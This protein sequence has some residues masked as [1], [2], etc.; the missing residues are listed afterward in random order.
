MKRKEHS[1]ISDVLS[2]CVALL[3][4]AGMAYGLCGDGI[5]DVGETCDTGPYVGYYYNGI[6]CS[7]NC[8]YQNGTGAVYTEITCLGNGNCNDGNG[9]TTDRCVTVSG[10]G[11]CNVTPTGTQTPCPAA[12][13]VSPCY[14]SSCVSGQ[15]RYS[16][17]NGA[18]NGNWTALHCLNESKCWGG[19]QCV[20]GA[21]V[22]SAP[23][24]TDVTTL[25]GTAR[26]SCETNYSWSSVLAPVITGGSAVFPPTF[27]VRIDDAGQSQ[28]VVLTQCMYTLY[29]SANVSTG[30]LATDYAPY[31][32]WGKPFRKP[33]STTWLS[34]RCQVRVNVTNECNISQTRTFT[35][36]FPMDPPI[37]NKLCPADL[38]CTDFNG[39][40]IDT[41]RI[42]GWCRHR[43]FDITQGCSNARSCVTFPCWQASC[44]RGICTYAATGSTNLTAG[45][46]VSTKTCY[47]ESACFYDPVCDPVNDNVV[48]SLPETFSGT[49]FAVLPV[50]FDTSVINVRDMFLPARPYVFNA[51]SV[52][53]HPGF[54][55]TIAQTGGNCA[56][57]PVITGSGTSSATLGFTG[58]YISTRPHIC[59]FTV[60]ARLNCQD[61]TVLSGTI[62]VRI[63]RLVLD[64][65]NLVSSPFGRV[66]SPFYCN[67]NYS[68]S[69]F[70]AATLPYPPAINPNVTVQIFSSSCPYTLHATSGF[71]PVT[72]PWNSS[73]PLFWWSEPYN[74]S[75]P[76]PICNMDMQVTSVDDPT[77]FLRYNYDF[78]FPTLLNKPCI[79]DFDCLGNFIGERATCGTNDICFYQPNPGSTIRCN[80]ASD[81]EF[82]A[83]YNAS[84]STG[85]CDYV[86]SG[87]TNP[88]V[89]AYGPVCYPETTCAF[90]PTCRFDRSL[91]FQT[92]GSFTGV[93]SPYTTQH[94]PAST[95]FARS[96]FLPASPF[97]FTASPVYGH[98]GFNYTIAQI[99]SCA[100]TVTVALSGTPNATITLAGPW[101]STLSSTCS[102]A[103]TGRALCSGSVITSGTLAIPVTGCGDGVLQA[104]EQCDQGTSNGLS[105]SCCN[106]TCGFVA[107]GV[108]RPIAGPCDVAETCTGVSGICPSDGYRS[109]SYQCNVS[110]SP[111]T[112]NITCSGLSAGCPQNYVINGGACNSDNN[113][114]SV[115]TCDTAHNCIFQYNTS[116]DDGFYCNGVEGC[117]ATTGLIVPGTPINCNDN[118]SCTSDSCSDAI[119]SCVHAPLPNTTGP[120]GFNSVGACV[121]GN[122]SCNGTGV[123]PSV[124]CVGAV[125]PSAEICLPA[126]VDENC[127]GVA[128]EGCNQTACTVDANCTLVPIA[129]CQRVSCDT[130]N[131]VCVISNE[132][133][134]TS[135]TDGLSCTLNDQCN[136]AG[137]CVGTAAVC[138]DNNPCTQDTCLEPSGI[139]N[140]DGAALA[141]TPCDDSNACTY[142][143]ACNNQG[144][145]IGGVAITCPATGN[146]CTNSVCNTTSGNCTVVNL[147]GAC[148][149]GLACTL[150][151]QCINGNCT[152]SQINCNDN[153]ACTTDVCVEPSGVCSNAL[154]PGKCYVE[155][156]CYSDG[157][158]SP[159]DPCL[160]CNS[161]LSGVAWSYTQAPGVS[162]TDSN[163]CTVGDVCVFATQTCTGAPVDCSNMTNQCNTGSCSPLS[164]QC[165]A[166]PVSSGAPCSTGLYCV[167]GQTCAAGSCQGGA[168]RDCSAFDSQCSNGLCN[169]TADTCYAAPFLDFTP[170]TLDSLVCNGPE[171]CASGVCVNGVAPTCPASTQCSYYQCTEPDGCTQFFNSLQPCDDGNVCT[172]GDFCANNADACTPGPTPLNCNDADAC[173]NDFCNATGGCYHVHL[174]NC[175]NCAVAGDCSAAVCY[176][177]TC[178]IAGTCNY[179][180]QADGTP[181]SDGNACNGMETCSS[182]VCNAGAPL[183]CDDHNSCTNDTCVPISGCYFVDAPGNA[184]DDGDPCTVND[185]CA[186]NGTGV[187]DPF[188]CPN[189]TQCQSFVCQN[190]NGSA[191]CVPQAI[192]VGQPCETDN[193]CN[194]SCVD[195]CQDTDRCDSFGQ[196]TGTFVTCR[197]PD[198]CEFNVSCIN[199]TCTYA[200]YPN[201]TEC[202]TNNLCTFDYC[203]G[204]GVC[205]IGAVV[206]SC[207]PVDQ[208]HGPGV[209]V[210]ATGLCTAPPLPNGTACDDGNPCTLND[211]C[212]NGV[213]SVTELLHCTALDQCHVQGFCNSSTGLCSNPNAPDFTPCNDGDACTQSDVCISGA[214]GG[215]APV[216]C[217]S[218][219]PCLTTFCDSLTGCGSTFNSAPCDDSNACTLN[220]TCFNGACASATGVVVSCEDGNPCTA[221]TCSPMSGCAHSPIT[222][223]SVC[224]NDNDC[225]LRPCMR[226]VCQP[227]STCTYVVDDSNVVGCL[228][229]LFCNGIEYCAA[230]VCSQGMPPSCDDGNSCT[231]DSCNY[232]LNACQNAPNPILPFCTSSNL[233]ATVSR[234]DVT[235]ACVPQGFTV[236]SPAPACHALTGCNPST[237][238]C[239]YS[240][241]PD[242][243]PCNDGNPCTNQDACVSGSCVGAGHVIC[244]PID[245]CH[246]TGV[247][248]TLTGLCSLPLLP[249]GAACDDGLFCTPASA[250]AAGFCLPTAAPTCPFPVDTPDPQC[251]TAMC[252][253]FGDT[254]LLVNLPD[255]TPCV[256]SDPAGPC[257]GADEC[258][259]GRCTRSY[260]TGQLCRAADSSGCDVPEF[261]L[262]GE[263]LCPADASMPDATPCDSGLYCTLG[264]CE[265]GTCAA[266]VPRDCSDLDG[267]CRVGV[268]SESM[269]MCMR[270]NRP[271]NTPCSTGVVEECIQY[272]SCQ[273]GNC[274]HT[275]ADSHTPCGNN[276]PCFLN[277]SCSGVN[278]LCIPQ[279]FRDCSALDNECG[280][281]IC[282]PANG[283]CF[284]QPCGQCVGGCTR[285]NWT[286][287][288]ELAKFEWPVVEH[289]CYHTWDYWFAQ[290]EHRGPWYALMLEFVTAQLSRLLEGA[291]MPPPITAASLEAYLLLE[292]CHFQ[293]TS[294]QR[295]R[296]LTETLQLYN[297]GTRGPG[298]CTTRWRHPDD[299]SD[300]N[301]L[302]EGFVAVVVVVASIMLICLLCCFDAAFLE[303]R[304]SA[305][306]EF[307]RR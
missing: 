38:G 189:S 109:S 122:Y 29:T 34:N 104:G 179:A 36:T 150:N 211:Q 300:N 52:Y 203:D 132:T 106:S 57:T 91:S 86:S 290:D 58:P 284:S 151:D 129:E 157:A 182:G 305:K 25:P 45:K 16:V 134:G 229:S 5:I 54:I 72:V 207:P 255:Y 191:V 281:G 160:L 251:Q 176:D 154:Q 197:A 76:Y 164:G 283:V 292:K 47:N 61:A 89:G 131:H 51:S 274:T 99:G 268:C 266:S 112:V 216:D 148:S 177:V 155:G 271:D 295:Y 73:S 120:C 130:I 306:E 42:N 143:D 20:N 296:N 241:L 103:V 244:A 102:F 185:R 256:F 174:G 77:N 93:N 97:N 209:C 39:A 28:G 302:P 26:L 12:C 208:C 260:R 69:D 139:C 221:D 31:F 201:G 100:A 60:S 205:Q 48:F 200:H 146:Q 9:A 162:C 75:Y 152:G 223:Y 234:C 17:I 137:V 195:H 236:C 144:Q 65:A 270:A 101:N 63:T 121:L 220:T 249:D 22:A 126:L 117:N 222:N 62:R 66:Q 304:R 188:V 156:T 198:Q 277:A 267:M 37:S 49:L 135:C 291:C 259:M 98:P 96:A 258:L 168:F 85:V 161:T 33:T 95:I 78:P 215:A 273:N 250:C 94:I 24:I 269:R 253:D 298:A 133:A 13:T 2:A 272:D 159:S 275:F 74:S 128:D 40:T 214:C 115:E 6:C 32:W 286:E 217:S 231:I 19:Y 303:R 3:L 147:L 125:L 108:C 43:P 199:N 18:L 14:A 287:I 71:S 21:Q 237:G 4:M 196:C 204:G 297:N 15:C 262:P 53:G 225:P 107:S 186:A 41:C 1:A 276:F 140:Y 187:S 218:P 50:Y 172:T 8:T 23:T 278:M 118:D 158:V 124:V 114:C 194:G 282:N 210:P 193:P 175:F 184:Y 127:N 83:C 169:E 80:Q 181:C 213:C 246:A 82:F 81:C 239:E 299:D 10:V 226:G 232:T 235:G 119:D 280:A 113:L 116:Y 59:N 92:A 90:S 219:N 307:Y 173:T 293:I 149:D 55:Y 44:S 233:C 289:L 171:Y 294:A 68:W 30:V 70:I 261:C 180:L 167:V 7:K 212:V 170:C 46:L 202:Q 79:N 141:N 64:V 87:S 165:V 279:A 153:L 192:N 35:V 254:C 110:S 252:D 227:N 163:L 111:C 238:L 206:V 142:D 245:Q 138:N 228:D 67:T 301:S 11:V 190:T 247:C 243:S 178:S 265:G 224:S 248:D 84:C 285:H 242:A 257:S 264:L 166:V 27:T 123:S 88:I 240:S 230:G 105:T 263:D 56:A 136:G 183:V 288:A 145:C